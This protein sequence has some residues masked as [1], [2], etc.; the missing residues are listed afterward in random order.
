[1]RLHKELD[2]QSQSTRHHIVH[3]LADAVPQIQPQALA[4][5]PCELQ[6][7]VVHLNYAQLSANLERDGDLI[8]TGMFDKETIEERALWGGK[9]NNLDAACQFFFL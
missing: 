8:T 5:A 3:L 4:F 6:P 1:M 2:A 7:E 9:A